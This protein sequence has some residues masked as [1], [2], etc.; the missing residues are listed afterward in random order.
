MYKLKRDGNFLW[1]DNNKSKYPKNAI[2]TEKNWYISRDR[3]ISRIIVTGE[4]PWEYN[5]Y[6]YLKTG[7]SLKKYYK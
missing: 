3:I 4:D 6:Y 1:Y 5:T 7:I 2:V